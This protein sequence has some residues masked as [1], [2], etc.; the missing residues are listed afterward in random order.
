MSELKQQALKGIRWTAVSAVLTAGGGLVQTL[1]LTRILEKGDFGIMAIITVVV[2]LSVQL[3]DMGFSNALL[4]EQNATKI[5]ISSLFWLNVSMGLVLALCAALLAPGIARFYQVPELENLMLW[6]TPAFIFSG[7]AALYQVLLQKSLRFRTLATIEILS[8]V[9]SF[10]CTITLAFSGFGVVSLV[11]GTL[12]K[13]GVSA[14]LLFFSGLALHRPTMQFSWQNLQ[15]M[16]RFGYFQTLEKFINYAN[17]NFDT[18]LI[19]RILGREVLG[20]YDVVKRLLIQPM[21]VI[22]P[23]VCKVSYPVMAQVQND[24]PRLRNIA[25]RSLQLVVSANAPIYMAA[26]VGADVLV[27][28]VFGPQWQSGIEP[29]RW[30]A[31]AFLM[32]TLTNPFG[33]V[34]IAKGKMHLAVYL[35]LLMFAG[36]CI[37][38]VTG[39][40]GGMA[41]LLQA[42]LVFYALLLLVYY[43]LI[44][45]PLLGITIP[46][47]VMHT[48]PECL[49]ALISYAV[50]YMIFGFMEPSWFSVITFGLVGLGLYGAGLLLFIRP[51]LKAELRQMFKRG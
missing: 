49:W 16:W 26:A 12:V 20:V 46:E 10:A 5:Q 7:I 1:I 32:R 14:L 39:L 30:L 43:I 27:P 47:L 19:G 48:L 41:G 34:I 22:N 13:T 50:A 6:I 9:L 2:G 36:L 33:G 21:Y 24:A 11:A 42:L 17:V 3:V 35:Q 15:P 18:L 29:F 37:A 44:I 31:V 38:V 4:R 51:G 23:V 25:L 28:V 40:W 45:K 8:F